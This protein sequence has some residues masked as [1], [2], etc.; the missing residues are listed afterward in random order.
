MSEF[1]APRA[2]E[3][4]IDVVAAERLDELEPIWRTL[5]EH[6]LALTPY[7]RERARTPEE[8]WEAR[9]RVE[10]EWLATEPQSF[11]LAARGAPGYLGYAFVRVRPGAQFATSWR[12]SDP[13]AELSILAVL[14]SAR[15]R[16]VGTALLDAVEDRLTELGG[17][18]HDHRRGRGQRRGDAFVRTTRGGAFRD[19]VGAER[20]WARSRRGSIGVGEAAGVITFCY[21]SG[22]AH[23]DGSVGIGRR[24]RRN[25]GVERQ[26][27]LSTADRY[28]RPIDRKTTLGAEK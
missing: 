13:L 19:R 5:Y 17:G 18:G 16:G 22:P 21:N 24:R 23:G 26:G 9:R 7:M 12:A 6:H 4:A 3:F 11:V 15:G 27:G 25:P 20:R 14:P 10:R 8:A 2:S 28:I 1:E